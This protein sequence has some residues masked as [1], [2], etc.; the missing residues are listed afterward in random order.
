MSKV[1]YDDVI[2]KC[3]FCGTCRSK[4]YPCDCHWF[5]PIRYV[6]DRLP[7]FLHIGIGKLKFMYYDKKGRFYYE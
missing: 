3:G 2:A 4:N 6:I 1:T 5:G 7:I